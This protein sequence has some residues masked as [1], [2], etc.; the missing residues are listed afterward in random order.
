VLILTR[1]VKIALVLTNKIYLLVDPVPGRVIQA[2]VTP[3]SIEKGEM[4]SVLDTFDPLNVFLAQNY[5][6]KKDIEARSTGS[7]AISLII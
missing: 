4:T 2:L 5:L 3:R 7:S 1:K 6:V